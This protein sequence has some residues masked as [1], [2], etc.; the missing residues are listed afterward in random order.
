MGRPRLEVGPV[1]TLELI[2]PYPFPLLP[3]CA[4]GLAP[5]VIV[6]AEVIGDSDHTVDWLSRR[7]HR[8]RRVATAAT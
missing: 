5:V 4:M 2:E 7:S 3:A 6:D 8:G 1:S